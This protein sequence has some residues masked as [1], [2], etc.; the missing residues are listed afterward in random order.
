MTQPRKWSLV[1]PVAATLVVPLIV[2]WFRYPATHL[3]PGFGIFPPAFVQAAPG[4]WWPYFLLMSLAVLLIAAFLLFPQWFGF[5]TPA[6]PPTPPAPAKL[7]A[8]FWLGL[9]L[10]L[11]FW[12]VMWA[13]PPA[14]GSLVYYAFSPMWWGFILVLDGLNYRRRGGVSLLATK[15]HTLWIS[16]LVS[17]A[18]WGYFEYYDYF[19][20][21]NWYYPNGQMPEL[22]HATI[23]A[24]FLI[25]YTTVWPA[26]FEWYT[27]LQTFPQLAGRYA[28]GPRLQFPSWLMVWGGLGLIGAM[29]FWHYLL[30]WVVWVGPMIVIAGQLLRL[31]VW[32]PFS[33]VSQ[34]NWTPAVLVALGSMFNGFFWEMWNYGSQ[35]ANPLSPVAPVAPTNPNYWIYDIPF[36]NVIHVF[37]EMPLLGYFGYLPFGILV[38]VVFVWAGALFGFDASLELPP[39]PAAQ[40][41]PAAAV[42]ANS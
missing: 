25:A 15:P 7:P 9:A 36:V 32:S 41:S 12:W 14:V 39:A 42:P 18:G 33:A 24:L 6:P 38:W 8:W 3:P 28:Q 34:G 29:V 31:G 1:W 17:V 23:V 40:P 22:S 26:L 13:R 19:V 16:A 30:F 2:A 11:F 37:S 4:F 35:H 27:L 5:A 21:G 10:T 20:I